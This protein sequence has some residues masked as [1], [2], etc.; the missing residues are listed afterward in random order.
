MSDGV[1]F[2]LLRQTWL[3]AS[4][5]SKGKAAAE[6]AANDMGQLV[7]DRARQLVHVDTGALQASIHVWNDGGQ[8]V[9]GSTLPYAIIEEVVR[10]HA[11]IVP[12]VA[13]VGRDADG[14][15]RQAMQEAGL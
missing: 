13:E 9:V 14:I 8:I 7:V 15:M 2:T 11:Y 12:A 6:R 5:N 1:G 3:G 10:G 4:I